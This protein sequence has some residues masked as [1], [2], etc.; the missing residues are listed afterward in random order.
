MVSAQHTQAVALVPKIAGGAVL[1]DSFRVWE[2]VVDPV[3]VPV[4]QW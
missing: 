4:L 2:V 3:A 1:K